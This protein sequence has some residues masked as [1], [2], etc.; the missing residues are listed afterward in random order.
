MGFLPLDVIGAG[1][2]MEALGA[3]GSPC[4]FVAVGSFFGLSSGSGGLWG[5]L[6]GLAFRRSGTD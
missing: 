6:A 2:Q 4:V 1:G 5:V 3:G